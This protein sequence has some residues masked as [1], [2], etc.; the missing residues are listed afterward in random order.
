MKYSIIFI[1]MLSFV[2]EQNASKDFIQNLKQHIQNEKDNKMT[3]NQAC[4]STD[5]CL[6]G[7]FV[8]ILIVLQ[9]KKN[10]NHVYLAWMKNVNVVNVKVKHINGIKYVLKKKI[11]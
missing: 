6:K 11:A 9:R 8:K 7:F 4:K 2:C 3:Q 5:D 1:F 10:L